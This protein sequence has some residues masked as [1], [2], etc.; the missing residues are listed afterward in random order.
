M[1]FR[2]RVE[3][4]SPPDSF[5]GSNGPRPARR[6]VDHEETQRRFHE[7]LWPHLAAVLRT[8]LILCGGNT[9]EAEDLA[10]ETMLKAFRATE[11]FAVGTDAKAWLLAILR[12]ARI[13]RLRSSAAASGHVSLDRLPQE[14]ADEHPPDG[15]DARTIREDPQVVLEQFSDRQ[16]IEALQN[17]PEEI[18]WT[19]LL[20]DVEGMDHKQAAQVLAVPVGTIKSRAHRGR[21]MLKEVLLPLAKRQRIVRS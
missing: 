17:L 13:D 5:R 2:A 15:V 12:N 16:M 18:R 19:L 20:V 4:D 7:L 9:A 10:Q 11:R 1:D 21:A 14:P 3:P 6:L 8:A